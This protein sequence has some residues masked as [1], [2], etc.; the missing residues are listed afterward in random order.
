MQASASSAAPASTFNSRQRLS[1]TLLALASELIF[2]T[3]VI[4][5]IAPFVMLQAAIWGAGFA[6]V[7][8]V[9]AFTFLWWLVQ[10]SP[11]TVGR[12]AVRRE[13]APA[14]FEMV[15]GLCTNAAAPRIHRIVL[16]NELNAAAYQTGGFL[17]LL[18]SRRTLIL[19]VPLLRMLNLDEVKAVI[20]HEL[21][22]F[23]R[24]H[25]R[26][27]HWIYRVRAKWDHYLHMQGNDS[28]VDG[29][30]KAIASWFVPYFV[31]RSSSWSRQCEFEADTV[32]ARAS[33]ARHL[34]DALARL[35]FI[36]FLLARKLP[37][38]L[39]S[40]RMQSAQAPGNFWSITAELAETNRSAMPQALAEGAN[41]PRR[42]QDTHPALRERATALGLLVEPPPIESSPCAGDILLGKEWARVLTACNE[43]WQKNTQV[44][45]RFDHLRMRWLVTGGVHALFSQQTAA[46]TELA[47]AIVQEQLQGD[48]A[49][50]ALLSA[51]AT[52]HPEMAM[53]HFY[54]GLALLERGDD[55][56]IQELRQSIRLDKRIALGAQN[57]ICGYLASHGDQK[58]AREAV[59]RRRYTHERLTPLYEQLWEALLCRSLRAIAPGAVPLLA[60]VLAG[61][62]LTDG[63][64]AVQLDL[65]D[66]TGLSHTVNILVMRIDHEQAHKADLGEDDLRAR[67]QNYL[68]AVIP[69]DQLAMVHTVY[70]SEPLNP[71]LLKQLQAVPGSEI[72]APARPLNLD[73]IRIDSI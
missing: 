21:G 57:V 42:A 37:T 1:L 26:L 72:I 12:H 60:E 48:D 62:P 69:P 10:P 58:A 54:L 8:G 4:L 68:Q 14:L 23:S 35:E 67:Y 9:T 53:A 61:E 40:L 3:V 28:F 64:W 65:P 31:S 39:S 20:A 22:H 34:T 18:G 2:V 11:G 6:A 71:R 70:T 50:L 44:S 46:Q 16:D 45:W 7:F 63:C 13:E 52:R 30:L 25:G 43:D 15:D 51:A 47:T 32:A 27:G 36:S 55:A 19:G 24:N 73:I 56:G 41:R 59:I 33:S 38:Q 29:G 66:A 49:S 5:P 17:S